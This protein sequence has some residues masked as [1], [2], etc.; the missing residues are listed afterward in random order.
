MPR[1]ALDLV[2]TAVG[3]GVLGVQ[4]LQV[5]RRRAEKQLL[6]VGRAMLGGF[7]FQAPAGRDGGSP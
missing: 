1:S 2:Y 4:R 6:S 7:S 5:E 3:F